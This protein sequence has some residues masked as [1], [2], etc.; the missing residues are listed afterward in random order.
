[1]RR[2]AVA[3]PSGKL[4]S[5][6]EQPERPQARQGEGQRASVKRLGVVAQTEE[7]CYQDCTA[8]HGSVAAVHRYR[9]LRHR[10]VETA[11]EVQHQHARGMAKDALTGIRRCRIRRAAVLAHL[12]RLEV[13]PGP[14][15]QPAQDLPQTIG[16][17]VPRTRPHRAAGRCSPASDPRSAW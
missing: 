10:G 11:V 9:R 12:M 15:T 1:M 16:R 3:P 4:H 2:S 7:G 13:H 17:E 5:P 6:G 8:I 14:I